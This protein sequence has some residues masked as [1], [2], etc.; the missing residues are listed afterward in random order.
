MPHLGAS[1]AELPWRCQAD[2]TGGS[3]LRHCVT[4]PAHCRGGSPWMAFKGPSPPNHSVITSCTQLRPHPPG[5]VDAQPPP[6]EFGCAVVLKCKSA[7][8]HAMEPPQRLAEPCAPGAPGAR[9]SLRQALLCLRARLHSAASPTS[10]TWGFYP[11]TW[12]CIFCC[13]FVAS[14][15]LSRNRK[16]SFLSSAL[17]S[18]AYHLDERF[19]VENK[20]SLKHPFQRRALSGSDVP[21]TSL[22]FF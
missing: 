10:N 7:C 21:D 8:D 12:S 15:S 13:I 18:L 9:F 2:F 22:A 3:H 19:V 17:H 6:E 5:Q 4:N 1:P 11:H 14:V 16:C 20:C